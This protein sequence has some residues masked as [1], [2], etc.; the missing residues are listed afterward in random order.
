M[1]LQTGLES[2]KQRQALC[3]QEGHRASN[4]HTGLG[5]EKRS[6]AAGDLLLDLD[7][8]HIPPGLS[9]VKRHL[10]V[11]QTCPDGLL[12]GAQSIKQIARGTWYEPSAFLRRSRIGL[13]PFFQQ[14]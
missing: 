5:S 6:E 9:V 8:T 1:T 4:A 13:I 2:R 12:M 11:F 14:G 7:Q 3:A 10:H